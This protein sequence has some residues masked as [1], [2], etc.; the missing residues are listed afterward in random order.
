M[1]SQQYCRSHCDQPQLLHSTC[2]G[3]NGAR[4]LHGC[5]VRVCAGAGARM[6]AAAAADVGGADDPDDDG[7]D[8]NEHDE[9]EK[10]PEAFTKGESTKT[11]WCKVQGSRVC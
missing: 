3:G 6:A 10:E 2:V 7:D 5:V 4:G 8:D 1:Y 9:G 11:C